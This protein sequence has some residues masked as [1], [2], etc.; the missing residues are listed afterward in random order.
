MP[1]A[2]FAG[3]LPTFRGVFTT[4]KEKLAKNPINK[5]IATVTWTSR[6]Y[7]AMLEDAL[8]LDPSCSRDTSRKLATLCA[9]IGR[10]LRIVLDGCHARATTSPIP[11]S[12]IEAR[13]VGQ[14]ELEE[15]ERNLHV[16]QEGMGG[17]SKTSPDFVPWET[18]FELLLHLAIQTASDSEP[19]P[20]LGMVVIPS[21]SFIPEFPSVRDQQWMAP[22]PS[23]PRPAQERNTRG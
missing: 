1:A 14:K 8:V 2:V 10:I 5:L 16:M 17:M 6:A 22:T 3:S 20:S 15:L 19:A 21:S 7:T 9:E 18:A 13:D 23:P 4:P 11:P 12:T